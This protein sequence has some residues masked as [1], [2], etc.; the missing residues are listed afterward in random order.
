METPDDLVSV[1]V[2][3][4]VPEAHL[5]KNLLEAE[6][7]PAR[8]SEITAYPAEFFVEPDVWVKRS[9]EDRAQAVLVEYERRQSE[10]RAGGDWVCPTCGSKVPSAFDECDVCHTPLGTV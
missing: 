6:G 5:I 1:Y 4:S 10:R 9:D 7:V 8:V 2:A 3:A